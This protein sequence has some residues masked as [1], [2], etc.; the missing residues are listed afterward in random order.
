MMFIRQPAYQHGSLQQTETGSGIWGAAPTS[1]EVYSRQRLDLG[2]GGSAYQHGSPQ[3]TETGSGIW[4][5]VPTSM[6]VYSRQRLDLGYGGQ[7]LVL[8]RGLKHH[9]SYLRLLRVQQEGCDACNVGAVVVLNS[10]KTIETKKTSRKGFEQ[11]VCKTKPWW[12]ML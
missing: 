6:E 4:G 7:R 8:V 3:R 10:T 11:V 12:I 1:M 9:T 2:Y 5:A